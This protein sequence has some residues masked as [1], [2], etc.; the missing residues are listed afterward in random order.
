MVNSDS[1]DVYMVCGDKDIRLLR[2]F[3]VSYELFYK[4]PG[5]IYLW[6][7]RKHEYLLRDIRL[8]KNLTL[9]FKDDVPELVDDDFKNQM[10]LKLIAYRYVESDWFWVADTDYLIVSPLCKADFF[11]GDKPY[12]YYCNWHDV[13]ERTFRS[14]SE[15]FLGK[16][17]PFQF[18]DE[19]QFVHSKSISCE[20]S[21]KYRPE[22]ILTDKYLAAE[23]VVYGAYAYEEFHNI[24]HWVNV[25]KYVGPMA[26]YKVNQRPPTYCELDEKV[27]L[28]DLPTV[29]YHVFWSHW[30]KAEEKMME[31]LIDAQLQEFGKVLVVP[32]DTRLYRYWSLAEIDQGSFSGIDGLYSD[33]WL[34]RE[35]WFRILTDH[36]STFLM[37]LLV[38]SPVSGGAF[39]SRLFININDR[40]E[41]KIL[42]PGVQ[43]IELQLD[44]LSENRI[45]FRFEGGVAEPRGSRTL[46]SQIGACRLQAASDS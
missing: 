29:K 33:G 13:A 12:W 45:S 1:M 32:E 34:M 18:L 21:K 24:Y 36:R 6:V 14:G 44:R 30:E 8:P 39:I 11:C 27:R 43:K 7:W 3:L 37:E 38:P 20:F 46:F 22:E 41:T 25:D 23:Q 5:N 9:L 17:I 28:R 2:H 15:S 19:Q 26:S 31:F 10:Y 42:Y 4:S 35:V 40:R 16:D